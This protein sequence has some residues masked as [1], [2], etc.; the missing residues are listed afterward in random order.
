MKNYQK[1]TH[2][3]NQRMID[4]IDS[5]LDIIFDDYIFLNSDQT[6]GMVMCDVYTHN[7]DKTVLVVGDD[8]FSLYPKMSVW[9]QTDENGNECDISYDE[10]IGSDWCD[11]PLLDCDEIFPFPPTNQAPMLLTLAQMWKPEKRDEILQKINDG[12]IT[13][14]GEIEAIK[15]ALELKASRILELSKM[16]FLT[17]WGEGYMT[18]KIAVQQTNTLSFYCSDNGYTETNICSIRALEIGESVNLSDPNGK[19]SV[20]RVA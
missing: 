13:N 6:G 8:G 3:L 4:F 9:T 2:T 20:T 18:E 10:C 5:E 17:V 12:T 14:T 16:T 11:I 7:D 19:Q 15:R 1:A